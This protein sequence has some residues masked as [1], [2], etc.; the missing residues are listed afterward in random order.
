MLLRSSQEYAFWAI[1]KQKEYRV[2]CVVNVV[3]AILTFLLCRQWC[4]RISLIVVE[5]VLLFNIYSAYKKSRGYENKVTDLSNGYIKYED[6]F[7]SCLQ[8]AENAVYEECEIDINDIKEIVEC[9]TEGECGFFIT[10]KDTVHASNIYVNKSPVERSVFY[11]NG[12]GY[13][14]NDFKEIYHEILDH[15]VEGTKVNGTKSQKSWYLPS[16]KRELL[17]IL[18]P[19]ITFF[20]LALIHLLLYVAKS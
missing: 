10:L 11:V 18:A 4:S 5:A 2:L 3:L 20:I 9:S 12:F 16:A 6:G 15:L 7:I 14:T 13:P 19:N 1:K 8:T 17:Q